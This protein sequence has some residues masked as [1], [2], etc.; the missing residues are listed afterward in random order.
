MNKQTN[1]Q[2]DTRTN[3]HTNKQTYKMIKKEVNKFVKASACQYLK[4]IWKIIQVTL[5][6]WLFNH[7]NNLKAGPKTN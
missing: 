2:T 5:S 6:N 7:L 1:E 4:Q 3:R